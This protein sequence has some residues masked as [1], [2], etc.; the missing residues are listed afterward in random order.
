MKMY[1]NIHIW[2]LYISQSKK[3]KPNNIDDNDSN[4]QQRK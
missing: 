3:E 4:E 1:K 2:S